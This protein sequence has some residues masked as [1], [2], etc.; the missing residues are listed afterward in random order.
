MSNEVEVP[1]VEVLGNTTI[2]PVE[3]TPAQQE[4]LDAILKKAMGRAGKDAAKKPPISK[5]S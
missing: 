5:P 2:E 4:K 1:K 3:F